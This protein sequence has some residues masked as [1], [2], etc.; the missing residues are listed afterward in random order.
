MLSILCFIEKFVL[1][2]VAAGLLALLADNA[3]H[4][5][6]HE[7]QKFCDGVHLYTYKKKRSENNVSVQRSIW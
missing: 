5:L 3:L 6:T 7:F 1:L 2:P 4:S